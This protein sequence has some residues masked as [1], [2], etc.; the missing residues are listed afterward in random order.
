MLGLLVLGLGLIAPLLAA[1]SSLQAFDYVIVGGGPAGLILANKLSADPK[2]TVAVVE[3]GDEQFD[4][5]NV[6]STGSYSPGLGTVS[7]YPMMNHNT[8]VFSHK[9]VLSICANSNN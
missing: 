7:L 4:N 8:Q 9:V 3:A 5:P 1:C 2:I 6:T